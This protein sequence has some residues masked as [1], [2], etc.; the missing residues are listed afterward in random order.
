[1][2]YLSDTLVGYYQL[3]TMN[4]DSEVVHQTCLRAIRWHIIAADELGEDIP[5]CELEH[6]LDAPTM[7]RRSSHEYHLGDISIP[8]LSIQDCIHFETI[9]RQQN[10][11][12][13]NT[14]LHILSL[15]S[16]IRRHG[17]YSHYF[18]IRLCKSLSVIPRTHPSRHVREL[19]H[20]ALIHRSA[21]DSDTSIWSLARLLELLA[22][23]TAALMRGSVN[24][25]QVYS[26]T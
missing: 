24:L 18:L 6:N 3:L 9:A 19:Q 26:V 11:D 2:S 17:S 20:A 16:I 14:Y 22:S 5:Q 21:A 12:T 8:I 13:W 23:L 25:P 15:R 10:L 7:W 4:P 1:M